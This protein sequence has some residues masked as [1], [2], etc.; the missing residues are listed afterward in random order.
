MYTAFTQ[1]IDDP[2][3]AVKEILEQLKPDENML[4]NT[5]GIVHFFYEFVDTEVCR[6]VIDALP[7]ELV[8]EVSMYIG[9]GGRDAE[10]AMSVVMLTS[11]DARF[12]VRTVTDLSTKSKELISD[13]VTKLCTE[14]CAEEKPKMIMPI[15]SLL[16][17][18]TGDDLVD[19][20]NA[21]PDPLPFFGTLSVNLGIENTNY[22]I[23]GGGIATDTCT[24]IAFYGNIEPTFHITTSFAFDDSFSDAAEITDV[25]GSI[26]K[27]VDGITAVK[28]IE[29]KGIKVAADKGLADSSIW[30]IPA[31]LTYPDGTQIVRAFIKI[32]EG[33]EFMYATGSMKVGAKVVFSLLDGD[34]TLASAAKL[35]ED[36]KNSKGNDIIAYSCAARAWS[37]GTNFFAEA[38][39]VAKCAE[40]YLEANGVPLNYN[41]AYSG[42]ELCPVKDKD[43]N[44]V[45]AFHNYT[46]I[47]CAFN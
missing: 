30:T 44:M 25:D 19:I 34:K 39:K 29:G 13:E 37:L 45:N 42:G 5:V 40:G 31:I 38:Q 35:V 12:T 47:A 14:L 32:V 23:A 18:F 33:T 24:F 11:D 22:V 10:T 21:L 20:A 41:V 27:E 43:G 26:L 16:P 15:L 28:F 1:E 8:G 4:K 9:A 7:F 2:E 3:A 36:L 6:A 17:H 46:L